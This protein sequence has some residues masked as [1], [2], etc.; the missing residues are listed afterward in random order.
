MIQEPLHSLHVSTWEFPIDV[1][2]YDRWSELSE[3]ERLA[4]VQAL[5][6]CYGRRKRQ[7]PRDA[8]QKLPRLSLPLHDILSQLLSIQ[9]DCSTFSIQ[10]MLSGMKE[11]ALP[12]WAW[13]EEQWASLLTVDVQHFCQQYVQGSITGIRQQLVIFASVPGPQTDFCLPFLGEQTFARSVADLFFPT[14]CA[15]RCQITK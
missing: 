1:T 10:L 12:Y 11:Y 9:T 3:I 7:L 2:H 15:M 6:H 8:E 4:L 14:N 5:Q 13:S